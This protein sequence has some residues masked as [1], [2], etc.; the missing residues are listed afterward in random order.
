[1]TRRPSTAI[2]SWFI[3]DILLVLSGGKESAS[4]LSN[5]GDG[6]PV[7]LVEAKYVDGEPENEENCSSETVM[8]SVANTDVAELV[9]DGDCIA[10][11]ALPIFT[12]SSS[13]LSVIPNDT[14]IDNSKLHSNSGQ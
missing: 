10:A 6:L 3:C 2:A 5:G 11:R 8:P 1:M 13:L 12:A 7:P 14:L 9:E 4:L